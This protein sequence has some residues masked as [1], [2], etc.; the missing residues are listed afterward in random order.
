MSKPF[1]ERAASL[2]LS[3]VPASS[4]DGP[5]WPT[6]V[7]LIGSAVK[8]LIYGCSK[9]TPSQGLRYVAWQPFFPSDPFGRLRNHRARIN[10][11]MASQWTG[12]SEQLPDALAAMWKAVDNGELTHELMAGLYRENS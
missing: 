1:T 7:D 2:L 5:D 4:A 9:P 10:V 6:F 12:P 11:A 3:G 8:V